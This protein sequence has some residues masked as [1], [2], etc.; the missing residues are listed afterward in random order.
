[1]SGSSH[2]SRY[3]VLFDLA[4]GGMATVRLGRRVG[5]AGF[6]RLVVIKRIHRHLVMNDDARAMFLDEALLTANVHHPNVVPIVDVFD[7]GGELA[8]VMDYVES[9]SLSALLSAARARD[10]R[11][12]VEV[13]SRIVSDTLLG[14]DAAHEAVNA[15]GTSLALVHRDI[16]PQ[17]IIVGTDGVTRLID[18]GIAKAAERLTIT[19]DDSL[20][21]K[22]RYMSP[23]Q[24]RREPVDRRSDV[25]SAALVFYEALSGRPAF[26]S[27]DEATIWMTVVLGEIEPLEG[28]PPEVAA[29]LERALERQAADRFPTAREFEERLRAAIPPATPARVAACVERYLGPRIASV[30]DS[31]REARRGVPS[32]RRSPSPPEAVARSSGSLLRGRR[33]VLL[34]AAAVVLAPT[35]IALA[36]L[37]PSPH[38]KRSDIAPVTSSSALVVTSPPSVEASPPSINGEDGGGPITT[39]SAPSREPRTRPPLRAPANRAGPGRKLH[40]N[41]YPVSSAR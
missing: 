5:A 31:I 17:N 1:M 24:G 14:L 9:V 6:D 15:E 8:L 18:F 23:E 19:K 35:L 20:K 26:P 28:F 30:R 33:R 10:E 16:S 3:D 39:A 12:P 2:A 34:V 37:R 22:L 25:Y 13:V 11:L 21:G 36:L 32:S 41:P 27:D 4:A 38:D 7:D 29:V 40:D